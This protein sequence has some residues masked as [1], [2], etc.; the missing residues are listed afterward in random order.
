MELVHPYCGGCGHRF[1]KEP[2]IPSDEA[3]K[4]AQNRRCHYCIED[5]I[6]DKKPKPKKYDY[7]QFDDQAFLN[8]Y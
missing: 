2:Q 3:T 1:F 4:L 6:E 8:G 5:A 7:D